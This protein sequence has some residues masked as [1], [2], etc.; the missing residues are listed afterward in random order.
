MK[1]KRT[2][3]K[4]WSGK[5]QLEPTVLIKPGTRKVT[6]LNWSEETYFSDGVTCGN[7]NGGIHPLVKFPDL[8]LTLILSMSCTYKSL[9]SVYGS[10]KGTTNVFPWWSSRT[11]MDQKITEKSPWLSDSFTN[12]YILRTLRRYSVY[13]VVGSQR[14][15]RYLLVRESLLLSSDSNNL[16][17]FSRVLYL[18]VW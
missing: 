10:T 2:C 18:R 15:I 5:S 4:T 3:E 12:I 17:H 14:F 6:Q 9:T 1:T 13:L 7:T 16:G 11:R 8:R